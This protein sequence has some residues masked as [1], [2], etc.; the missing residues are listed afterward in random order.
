MC[1]VIHLKRILGVVYLL[2]NVE[3]VKNESHDHNIREPFSITRGTPRGGG[4]RCPPKIFCPNN[5]DERAIVLN[6]LTTS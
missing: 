6:N 4:S 2:L 3:N 1:Q 5:R